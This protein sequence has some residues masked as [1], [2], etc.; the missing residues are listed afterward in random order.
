M[1]RLRCLFRRRAHARTDI[2]ALEVRSTESVEAQR[3][4]V[5]ASGAFDQL[6]RAVVGEAVV[7]AAAKAKSFELSAAAA[8]CSWTAESEQ[9][10]VASEKPTLGALA[11]FVVAIVVKARREV[12][13]GAGEQLQETHSA[14]ETDQ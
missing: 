7:Q 6:T 8:N 3:A 13:T 9:R 10:Q 14:L 2:V 4:C 11:A 12:A 5:A 1:L